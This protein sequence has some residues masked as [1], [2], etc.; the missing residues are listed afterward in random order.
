MR[1]LPETRARSAQEAGK[2]ARKLS[3]YKANQACSGWPVA[4]EQRRRRSAPPAAARRAA[5]GCGSEAERVLVPLT[6]AWRADHIH[7][8]NAIWL[9]LFRVQ[10]VPL[11]LMRQLDVMVHHL[12]N[13]FDPRLFVT[14]PAGAAEAQPRS[15]ER[16]FVRLLDSHPHAVHVPVTVE[17]S[18]VAK[19]ARREAIAVARAQPKRCSRIR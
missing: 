16:C 7:S 8:T 5:A 11:E 6:A 4:R 10:Y 13:E 12:L 1:T 18:V 9:P 2:R 3:R 15:A 14:Q 17:V 19:R